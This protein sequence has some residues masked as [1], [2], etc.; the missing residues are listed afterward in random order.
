[1]N[2]AFSVPVP[3]AAAVS[4]PLRSG[5]VPFVLAFVR[6]SFT[7]CEDGRIRPLLRSHPFQPGINAI[8]NLIAKDIGEQNVAIEAFCRKA[9]QV[10]LPLN[11][12]PPGL[13]GY[14]VPIQAY[15][16]SRKSQGR[17]WQP[18]WIK[19][20]PNSDREIVDFDLYDRYLAHW[21]SKG[22]ILAAPPE[23]LVHDQ[24]RALDQKLSAARQKDPHGLGFRVVTTERELAAWKQLAQPLA[25][26]AAPPPPA[27]A[28]DEDED[29]PFVVPAPTGVRGGPLPSP[30]ATAAAAKPKPPKAPKAAKAEASTADATDPSGSGAGMDFG[31]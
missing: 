25:A 29:A 16:P 7:F 24:L 10:P 30:A 6:K 19:A 28:A 26:P 31:E 20:I 18:A 4:L 22:L 17:Y 23:D 12:P 27:A 13:S 2:E 8:G 15:D 3:A 11:E 9:G 21:V 14:C 1:M 5:N